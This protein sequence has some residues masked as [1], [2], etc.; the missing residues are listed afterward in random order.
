MTS[1][2]APRGPVADTGFTPL[3]AA[4][5]TSTPQI[6]GVILVDPDG[7]AVDQVRRSGTAS[8]HHEPLCLIAAHLQIIGREAAASLAAEQLTVQT[9][10]CSFMCRHIGE[11]YVVVLCCSGAGAW[12]VK[13]HD[14]QT[15]VAAIASEAFG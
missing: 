6:D 13:P 2:F 14:L 1:P 3:L 11:G 5:L 8:A 12:Q 9:D 15:A 4:L 10:N 7:E